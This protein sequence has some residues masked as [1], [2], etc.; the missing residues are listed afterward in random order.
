[1]AASLLPIHLQFRIYFST[2]LDHM[3]DAFLGLE[4]YIKNR[5]EEYLLKDVLPIPKTL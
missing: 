1:M 2:I 3:A 5:T 4:S